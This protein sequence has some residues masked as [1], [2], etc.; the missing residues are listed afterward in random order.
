MEETNEYAQMVQ[1]GNIRISMAQ[2]DA[3][4]DTTVMFLR[5]GRL[6]W[7]LMPINIEQMRRIIRTV[8][9]MESQIGAMV[10]RGIIEEG[11]PF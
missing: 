10:S 9:A 7:E 1:F 11:V 6:D 5:E 8:D 4:R 2:K 3:R